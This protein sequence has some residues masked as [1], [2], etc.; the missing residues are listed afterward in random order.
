MSG[1]RIMH[2]VADVNHGPDGLSVLFGPGELHEPGGLP[3]GV[4][5]RAVVADD[6]DRQIAPAWAQPPGPAAV[7]GGPRPRRKRLPRRRRRKPPRRARGSSGRG[8]AALAGH[9]CRG[10]R[11]GAGVSRPGRGGRPARAGARHFVRLCDQWAGAVPV[12][13]GSPCAAAVH[14][15]AVGGPGGTA[16]PFGD[17][18]HAHPHPD[19]DRYHD[20]HTDPD[21]DANGYGHERG[22]CHLREQRVL[23]PLPVRGDQCE[24]RV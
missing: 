7:S 18:G 14:A 10:L 19:G 9:P 3:D 16:V 21:A 23:R 4:R 22:V 1:E 12:N 11:H 24:Q 17:D 8:Y 13:D 15:G 6:V 2:Q 5:F 20:N